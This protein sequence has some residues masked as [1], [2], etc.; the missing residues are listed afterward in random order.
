ME[1]RAVVESDWFFVFFGNAGG[2]FGGTVRGRKGEGNREVGWEVRIAVDFC[3]HFDRVIG[4]E[5]RGA[6]GME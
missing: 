6:I 1:K 2:N 5:G 3:G 4:G